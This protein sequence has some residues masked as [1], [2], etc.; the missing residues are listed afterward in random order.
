[1]ACRVAFVNREDPNHEP[2]EIVHDVLWA[3]TSGTGLE[4]LHLFERTDIVY[5]DSIVIATHDGVPSRLHYKIACTDDW[6]VFYVYLT[7]LGEYSYHFRLQNDGNGHWKD[8]SG[9]PFP[10]FDDCFDVDISSTPFTNTLPI[11]RLDLAVGQSA[12]IPMLYIDVLEQ[13]VERTIQRYTH[14]EKTAGGSLY[15][16]ESPDAN[17][18]AFISVDEHSLVTDYPGLFR[19]VVT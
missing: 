1:M 10:Q 17:F 6:R 13:K 9:T 5:A 14:L 16:F 7:S 3:P 11:R 8:K 18:T 19:R 2:D 4:Y 15:K 12:E